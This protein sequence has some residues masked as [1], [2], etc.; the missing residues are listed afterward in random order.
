[1]AAT[2]GGDARGCS[3][4]CGPQNK[5]RML[6][7]PERDLYA[8]LGVT[9]DASTEVIARAIDRVKRNRAGAEEVTTAGEVLL[10]AAQRARYDA[11]RAQHRVGQLLAFDWARTAVEHQRAAAGPRRP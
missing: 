3:A 6:Y 7:D 8:F 1:M 9:A 5:G 10:D 4:G 11:R 2:G